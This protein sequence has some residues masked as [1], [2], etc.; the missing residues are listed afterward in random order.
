M[1]AETN[2]LMFNNNCA[3]GGKK[4][5]G[6]LRAQFIWNEYGDTLFLGMHGMIQANSLLHVE[7][8]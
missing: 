5:I 4:K 8:A 1:F 6:K 7:P 3:R 2:L